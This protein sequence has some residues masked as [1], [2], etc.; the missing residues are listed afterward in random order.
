MTPSHVDPS[1]TLADDTIIVVGSDFA[2]TP[3]LNTTLG[4]DHWPT[5]A[6]VF[7]GGMPA[8]RVIGG[9]THYGY[10][11]RKIDPSTGAAVDPETAG[12]VALNPGHWMASLMN[13][14]GLSI[15]ELREEPVPCLATS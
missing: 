14:E 10:E 13:N 8:G 4:R 2:R 12:A 3:I 11:S 1:R 7:L 9:T 15:S 6:C 5:N